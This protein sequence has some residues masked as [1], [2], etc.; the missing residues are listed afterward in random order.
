[1]KQIMKSLISII[2]IFLMV[3]LAIGML[4]GCGSSEETLQRTEPSQ[5]TEPVQSTKPMQGA[6][7]SQQGQPDTEQ[8]NSAG[9]LEPFAGSGIYGVWYAD[10]LLNQSFI[11]GGQLFFYWGRIEASEGE[12]D[13]SAINNKMKTM[14]EEGIKATIQVNGNEKPDYLYNKVPQHPEVLSNQIKDEQA[15][16]LMYWHE[17]HVNAYINFLTALN[18][19]LKE[20]P[21]RDVIVGVRLNWNGMG[22]EH[23]PIPLNRTD[24]SQWNILPE[25]VSQ[26]VEYTSDVKLEYQRTILKAYINTFGDNFKIFCR[27]NLEDE[28]MTEYNSYFESGEIGFFATSSQEQPLSAARESE[29]EVFEKWCRTGKTVGYYEPFS[30]SI[31]GERWI[32]FPQRAYWRVLQ[33]MHMGI[34]MIALYGEDLK[35]SYGE[36]YPEH[37]VEYIKT[38]EFA[39]RYLGYHALPGQSPGAWVAFR[40][41]DYNDYNDYRIKKLTGDY[42]FL[43]ERLPESITQENVKLVGPD[44]QRYGAWAARLPVGQKM[45]IQLN[46]DFVKSLKGKAAGVKV[47]YYNAGE[48]AFNTSFGGQKQTTKITNTTIWEEATWSIPSADFVQNSEGGHIEIE[49]TSGMDLYFHMVEIVR[50]PDEVEG[51]ASAGPKG[52]SQPYVAPTPTPT[53]T[54]MPLPTPT[55]TPD[56]ATQPEEPEPTA[57]QGGYD[58]A[59][60]LVAHVEAESFNTHEKIGVVATTDGDSGMKING[61]IKGH[62]VAYNDIDFGQEGGKQVVYIDI[63]ICANFD[64][65]LIELRLDSAEGDLIGSH[66]VKSTGGWN[67]YATVRV[68]VEKATGKHTLYFV[69]PNTDGVN[70]NWFETYA[71][72][73]K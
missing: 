35:V 4:T 38:Y 26:G 13:W 67:S 49:N 60:E 45:N 29:Y 73:T 30:E 17:N 28:L 40:Y 62:W 58:G 39:D 64:G 19:H 57:S 55:P 5:G 53:P 65:G 47:I 34:S 16:T 41:S 59:T 43:A 56:P 22:T 70:I 3:F 32:S 21:Y 50:S 10:H 69:F 42:N 9:S 48:G 25:G 61:C 2:L 23:L 36:L 1:M 44:T 27:A 71:A 14:H 18:N 51:W 24:L 15:T 8:D 52:T 66:D 37:Q 72:E 54:P 33:D 46:A 7:S 20:S 68:P 12:Y 11:E 31:K 6:E 63:R